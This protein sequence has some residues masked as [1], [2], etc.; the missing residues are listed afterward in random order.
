MYCEILSCD[1][2]TTCM[3]AV[4]INIEIVFVIREREY[5]LFPSSYRLN[6]ELHFVGSREHIM[7]CTFSLPPPSTDGCNND[8]WSPQMKIA[9]IIQIHFPISLVSPNSINALLKTPPHTYIH[10]NKHPNSQPTKTH[11]F[12]KNVYAKKYNAFSVAL[13]TA[14]VPTPA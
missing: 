10:S 8:E 1:M 6:S 7:M 9:S 14:L 5:E 13:C 4:T 2:S 12:L 3:H 11:P